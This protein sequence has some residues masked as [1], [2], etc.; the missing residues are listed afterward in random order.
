MNPI[1]GVLA[2][3]IEYALKRVAKYTGGNVPR[4]LEDD[5]VLGKRTILILI[6]VEAVVGSP[7]DPT[8]KFM[9]K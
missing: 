6:D 4:E 2:G 3:K 5:V 8:D 7:D 9:I 1:D